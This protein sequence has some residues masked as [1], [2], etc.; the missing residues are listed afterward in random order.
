MPGRLYTPLDSDSETEQDENYKCG[1]CHKTFSYLKRF[2]THM[3]QGNCD[4]DF[5]CP[6]CD[7]KFTELKGLKRHL[8]RKHEKQIFQC[9][10][11]LKYFP[12]RKTV[13]KHL[14]NFHSQHE[15]KHCKKMYRNANTLRSHVFK[16]TKKKE[17]LA[18]T[19]DGKNTTGDNKDIK[20]GKDT[21]V[22]VKVKNAKE[23][24]KDK[25]ITPEGPISE[26]EKY[27]RSCTVCD[28]IYLSKGGYNKHIKTHKDKTENDQTKEIVFVDGDGLNALE[29]NILEQIED[30]ENVAKLIGLDP[31][32]AADP[33]D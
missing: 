21:N 2:N 25:T 31:T 14:A 28:K 13:D 33:G 3:K 5:K 9:A 27:I 18:K 8:R 6:K 1:K 10:E 30:H 29:A 26:T 19:P 32:Q 15:C 16:C 17:P 23:T 24:E 11:C 4:V 22:E 12:T 20:Q 7:L